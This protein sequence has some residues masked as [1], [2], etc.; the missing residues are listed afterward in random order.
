MTRRNLHSRRR[1]IS[2]RA[3]LACLVTAAS[4][5]LVVAVILKVL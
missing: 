3:A 4:F 1:P 5:A 2:A